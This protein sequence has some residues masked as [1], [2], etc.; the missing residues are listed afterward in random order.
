MS[1][2][3]IVV[4]PEPPK[5]WV[6]VVERGLRNYNIAATGIV[7]LYPVGFV[8]KDDGGAV[9]GGLLGNIAGGWLHVRSLWV[10]RRCRGRGYAIELMA[11]AERYAIAKRCVAGALQT[12]S[13]EAR[14]LYEKLGYRVFCELDGHP[15]EGH[16]RFHMAKRPLSG[17]DALRRDP[18]D[19]ATLAMSPYASAEVQGLITRGIQ[20]HA[21][22]AIGRPEQIW[23]GA[24]VF[25]KSGEGEILGGALGNTWGLWLYVSDVWVDT[26]I[27]GKGYATKLMTAI[28]NLALE[29]P[30]LPA[31]VA[32]SDKGIL[33]TCAARHRRQHVA[34]GGHL[35]MIGNLVGRIPLTARTMQHKAAVGVDR[36]A[37]QHRQAADGGILRRQFHL[38]E[39]VAQCHLQRFIEH[40]A[41]RAAVAVLADQR[42][43]VGE[44][45]VLERRHRDQQLIGQIRAI[46]HAGKYGGGRKASQGPDAPF[47]P[48]ITLPAPPG[49]PATNSHW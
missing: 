12:A 8:V 25:L 36:S 9:V 49:C 6:E 31:R 43:A 40:D 38:S 35:N 47:A 42:H 44:I 10:D 17:I 1:E 13:Y 28:E 14:P 27:R 15:V 16:R 3:S 34:R 48:L 37:L 30:G 33:G 24:N 19:R 7:E 29:L 20:T 41:E 21:S 45:A 23:R 4:E 18:R 2:I 11:A 26:A 32:Q 22:A 39:H 5:A 46:V